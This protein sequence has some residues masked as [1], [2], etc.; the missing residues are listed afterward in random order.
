MVADVE[1]E[2]SL[3]L[4]S[5][6]AK[7]IDAALA[8]A[9]AKKIV[10]LAA[11]KNYSVDSEIDAFF[12]KTSATREACDARARELVGHD[13]VVPVEVQGV[14]SYTIYAGSD[15]EFVVQ[16]RLKSLELKTEI[17]SL[18]TEVYG[19]LVPEVSFKGILGEE[20]KGKEQLYVYLMTRMRGM[21]HLDFILAHGHPEN[22]PE[23]F[24]WRKTL[25]EDVAS[26]MALSWKSPQQVSLEYRRRLRETYVADLELLDNSLPI[27]FR[28]IIH[29][30][31]DALDDIFSLPMVLLHR[32]FGTCNILVDEATCH[33]VG[34]IDWAEAEVCPF[35][36]N[37]HSLRFLSGKL[38]LREG[39]TRYN[40]YD[41]LQEVFWD[42]L[43]REIG[44]L[45][46]HQLRTIKLARALG[47]LLSA[48]FT[49]RLAN[50]Q[51]PVPIG[52]DERGRYNMMSL[53]GF[54][55]NPETMFDF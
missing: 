16:F 28:P 37:L 19:S 6:R 14:C 7:G 33:L 23:N 22:S 24:A 31:F 35:G 25:M 52:D 21:T 20:E 26:F 53:D 18:A 40:D 9:A 39:W 38:H 42:T 15:L 11:A 8:D 44:G 45:S 36:L 41:A 54:L 5:D 3:T 10:T 29:R 1:D 49:S 34:V 4:L 30:C 55:I 12:T 48:G 46:E 13:N 51:K 43:K 32:D 27:R 17:T 47:L 50:E 2:A